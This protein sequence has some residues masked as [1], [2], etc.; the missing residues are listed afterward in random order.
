MQGRIYSRFKQVK[1]LIQ[2]YTYPHSLT[3]H[4]KRYFQQH[5]NLGS[6]DRKELKQWFYAY[7][8]L[9]IRDAQLDEA[10]W[11]T[12]MCD[13]SSILEK[14]RSA[15]EKRYDHLEKGDFPLRDLISDKINPELLKQLTSEKLTWV[16]NPENKKDSVKHY[17][18][19]LFAFNQGNNI[20]V[21]AQIQDLASYQI[22]EICS[23]YLR[24]V[25]ANQDYCRF[26]DACAGAGGKSLSIFQQLK[27]YPSAWL[28]SDKRASILKSAKQRFSGFDKSR[29]QF[30]E[31]D[32]LAKQEVVSNK[33]M[34]IGQQYWDFVLLDVPCSGSGTWG[35]NSQHIRFFDK[36]LLD[37]YVKLQRKILQSI[38]PFVTQNGFLCYA[39]CSV[40]RT[41]NED[42]IKWIEK[43]FDLKLVEQ[44]Y[45]GTLGSDIMFIAVFQV[46]SN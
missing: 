44:E 16:I 14:L 3:Q 22:S 31:L 18:N 36:L 45:L 6:R 9:N 40:Y 10:I 11:K 2:S 41:E 37:K 4:L 32:L 23:N 38:M 12:L 15:T 30:L 25:M 43:E 28:V 5:R 13:E 42:Q 29:T 21:K 26:W 1:E 46:S 34:Q 35:R 19:R 8:K 7:F 27:E 39:T 20:D 33:L 17:Q 24:E